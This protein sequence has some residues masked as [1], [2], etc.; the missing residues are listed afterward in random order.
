MEID[1]DEIG[2]GHAQRGHR[3]PEQEH[4][5]QDRHRAAGE[6]DARPRSFPDAETPSSSYIA[7]YLATDEQQRTQREHRPVLGRREHRQRIEDVRCRRQQLVDEGRVQSRR[8]G[9]VGPRDIYE[10]RQ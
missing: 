10:W 9:R 6:A 2:I 5:S 1:D 4:D 3:P 8:N 7:D